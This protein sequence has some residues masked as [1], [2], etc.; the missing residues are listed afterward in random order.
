MAFVLFDAKSLS[1]A[2]LAN[3]QLDIQEKRSV[4]F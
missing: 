1:D 2:V 3:C 4:K